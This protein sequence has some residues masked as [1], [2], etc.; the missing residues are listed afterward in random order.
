HGIPAAKLDSRLSIIWIVYVWA[1]GGTV[2]IEG[3]D[4][5]RRIGLNV[6]DLMQPSVKTEF[7]FVRAMHLI[8]CGRQLPRILAQPVVAVRIRTDVGRAIIRI[9]VEINSRD[10]LE[11]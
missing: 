2:L 8:D 7:Q 1:G 10:P 4:A 6:V 5:H 11:P 3:K 9:G